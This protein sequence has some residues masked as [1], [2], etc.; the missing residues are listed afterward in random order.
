MGGDPASPIPPS[1]GM[2]G[3]ALLLL[4]QRHDP[5]N[6]TTINQ[7]PDSSGGSRG[8]LATP[9]DFI[10]P[11]RSAP[12]PPQHSCAPAEALPASRF[13]VSTDWWMLTMC[14]GRG[15]RAAPPTAPSSLR[16]EPAPRAGEPYRD[17]TTAAAQALTPALALASGHHNTDTSSRLLTRLHNGELLL[18]MLS[19]QNDSFSPAGQRLGSARSTCNS[20]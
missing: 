4:G 12:A 8:I 14:S 1:R 3:P 19:Y 17:P 20:R 16:G 2:V 18:K 6:N 11:P 7:P 5:G 9:A 13:R 10:A 15:G